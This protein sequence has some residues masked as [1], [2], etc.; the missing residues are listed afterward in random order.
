MH[1]LMDEAGVGQRVQGP[2][3][4]MVGASLVSATCDFRQ[5]ISFG[6][7][8]YHCVTVA[9]WR[10]RSFGIAHTFTSNAKIV[11]DEQETRLCLARALD[12]RVSALGIPGDFR[13]STESYE[14]STLGQ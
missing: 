14:A 4:G 7:R 12:G 10:G 3:F 2:R 1:K 5:P 8:I 9:E 13:K 6:D 11:A